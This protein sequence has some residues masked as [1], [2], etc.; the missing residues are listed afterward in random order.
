MLWGNL[1]LLKMFLTAGLIGRNTENNGIACQYPCITTGNQCF[2]MTF[3]HHSQWT[4]RHADIFHQTILPVMSLRDFHLHHK[5]MM[6]KWH[7][8]LIDLIRFFKTIDSSLKPVFWLIPGDLKP[9]SF[10]VNICRT[11]C[12]SPFIF[13]ISM[14]RPRQKCSKRIVQY[15]C[16]TNRLMQRMRVIPCFIS[17]CFVYR[18]GV[19]HPLCILWC[20]ITVAQDFY[21][22][23]P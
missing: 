15:I 20:T 22:L 9:M 2:S 19:F 8:I 12:K 18:K 7:R 4:C 16:I 6:C 1:L 21:I 10:Y 3:D 17:K 5:K 13:P 14:L 11:S 23:S